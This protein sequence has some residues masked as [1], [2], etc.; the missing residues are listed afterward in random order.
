MRYEIKV[1]PGSEF[2]SVELKEN[3][4]ALATYIERANLP[5]VRR[6]HRDLGEAISLATKGYVGER[7]FRLR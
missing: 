6:L 5:D 4:Y 7:V 3:P 2:V 1:V